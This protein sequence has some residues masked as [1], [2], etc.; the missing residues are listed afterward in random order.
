MK[1]EL[2][3]AVNNFAA[4]KVKTFLEEA[5]DGKSYVCPQKCCGHGR[6]GDG[7][8][9]YEGQARPW[10]CFGGGHEGN[11]HMS[12]VDVIALAREVDPTDTKEVAKLLAELFPELKPT[13]SNSFF[14]EKNSSTPARAEKSADGRKDCSGEYKRWQKALPNFIATQGGKWRG[15]TNETLKSVGAGYN[16]YYHSIN[17][18]Y[19]AQS[20]FWRSVKDG[21]RGMN[22]GGN[23]RL[24]EVMPLKVG[25]TKGGV[26]TV[27]FL[28]EGELNALSIAQ[29]LRGTDEEEYFGVAATG[30]A[31]FV[32]KTI[33]ELNERYRD[34][35]EK[36]MFI[37]LGDNDPPIGGKS[38]GREA[39]RKYVEG[40]NAN[41][42]PAVAE[43]FSSGDKK[44]DANDYLCKNGE[45]ALRHKLFDFAEEHYHELEELKKKYE[46]SA[47]ES[48][49][50]Q[51]QAQGIKTFMATEDVLNYFDAESARMSKYDGRTTGFERLDDCQVFVPGVYVLGGTPG[52][53]KT[54]FA[55]Q[56]LIQLAAQGEQGIFCSYEMS[57]LEMLSKAIAREICCERLKHDDTFF[58]S[59]TAIRLGWGRR[60][61]DDYRAAQKRF[62]DKTKNKLQIL[63]LSNTPLENLLVTLTKA[64]V[65]AG[66]KPLTIV[67][68]YLQ[69]IPCAAALTTKDRVDEVMLKLKTFQ[70]KTNTTL[71]LIS[72]LNRAGY[73]ADKKEIFSFKESGSIEYSADVA[74]VLFETVDKDI[75]RNPVVRNVTLKCL[76]NRL[77]SPYEIGF[78]YWAGGD[79]FCCAKEELKNGVD[80]KSKHSR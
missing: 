68:D 5:A 20:Y 19:D 43:F 10:H 30:S 70:R 71:I 66:D 17:L 35:D 55:W 40:F 80:E 13:N 22:K 26:N 12:N 45:E 63:E 14:R 61:N 33:R 28:T 3:E 59:S 2:F 6:G 65:R 41:R 49:I 32:D 39:A 36:P 57:G 21:S 53:G 75:G 4:D 44:I 48:E 56:L 34:C 72:S 79:Y 76:K 60:N 62:L 7:L 23:R 8:K 54:T 64:A 18:P 50:A 58:P 11:P 78:E 31:S 67:V 74:W 24:Y 46:E 52:A 25:K 9:Y 16:S 27:N 42:F 1:N 47:R 69:L 77:G 15:L 73:D 38:K 51:L 29:A 37:W